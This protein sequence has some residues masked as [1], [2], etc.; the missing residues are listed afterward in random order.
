M[1][2]HDSVLKIFDKQYES[3]ILKIKKHLKFKFY[4]SGYFYGSYI[5]KA[6][7]LLVS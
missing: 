2:N 5:W 3:W 6:E 1:R 7:I 4:S